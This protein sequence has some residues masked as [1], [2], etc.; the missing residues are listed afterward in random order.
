M[1]SAHKYTSACAA[2]VVAILLLP[3]CSRAATPS[4]DF[5][6]RVVSLLYP[7]GPGSMGYSVKH[8]ANVC[9]DGKGKVSWDRSENEVIMICDRTE[10]ASQVRYISRWLLRPTELQNPDGSRSDSA[11]LVS[12]AINGEI[13]D[14]SVLEVLASGL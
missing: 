9:I 3:S 14:R 10:P 6:E 1:N 11:A 4:A 8:L 12:V 2:I 5:L 7:S 13:I